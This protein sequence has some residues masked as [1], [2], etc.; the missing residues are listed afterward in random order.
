MN[1][2]HFHTAHQEDY[3]RALTEINNG[4]KTTHWM[5]YIFPQMKGLGHSETAQYYGLADEAEARSFLADP[6]LG[7]HLREISEILLQHRGKS[8]S[9]IFGYPDDLKLRSSMTLFAQVAG[10][11]SVFQEVLDEFFDG[12][13]CERT[14]QLLKNR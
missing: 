11:E 10:E 8:A 7:A 14:L 12:Q 6:I 9:A 4:K 5:W 13:K 3:H 2:D 1:L